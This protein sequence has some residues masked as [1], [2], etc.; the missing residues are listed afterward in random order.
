MSTSYVFTEVKIGNDLA[1]YIDGN[2]KITVQNGSYENPKPNA[3]SLP[4][5]STCP[6]S[7]SE[8]RASC[9]VYG[10]QSNAPEVYAKY[11]QNERV[12]HRIL[13]SNS[14]A[15]ISATT[16]GTWISEN[17]R[18]GFRWHVSGDVMYDRHAQWIVDVV[19]AS[20]GVLNWI[21]TRSLELVPILVQAKNLVVNV[22]A[23]SE[24][25]LLARK[26]AFE[27]KAR[28]CYLTR[29]GKIPS[30]LVYN[31]SV[32]FPDYD[33]RGRNLEKPTESKWWQS[34]TLPERR[35]V[36]PADFFGQSEHHRCGPCNKCLKSSILLT[37]K[38]RPH[39]L[40]SAIAE[41]D[42]NIL[43]HLLESE[44]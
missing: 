12:I 35:S 1:I 28:I 25:Y 17:C 36:C 15:K 33:L 44:E 6:G 4:H 18:Y 27:N 40:D 20:G 42:E 29:D 3:L 43:S 30:D 10:L 2:S 21:Y 19:N 37:G 23:D 13:M 24:N 39:R 22:S 26:V 41:E 5:I 14:Y 32:I 7:T 11:M 31:D 8:C 34:L 38:D 16:L 9:Y